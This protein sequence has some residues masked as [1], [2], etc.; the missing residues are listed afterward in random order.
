MRKVVFFIIGA[1]VVC[2]LAIALTLNSLDPTTV[3]IRIGDI[4]TNRYRDD[5]LVAV[6]VLIS[7]S[8]PA[9]IAFDT[10]YQTKSL[11]GWEKPV[12]IKT[13]YSSLNENL[14]PIQPYSVRQIHVLCPAIRM[15]HGA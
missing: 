15:R 14:A 1:V 4:E 11:S 2:G 9:P 5:S 7:N 12:T 10:T 6:S 3:V 13:W 8:S